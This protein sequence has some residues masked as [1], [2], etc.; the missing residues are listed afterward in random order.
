MLDQ[1]NFNKEN[2]FNLLVETIEDEKKLE[3]KYENMKKNYT[4]NVYSVIETKIK[5]L[6]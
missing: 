4:N 1:N 5:E 6:I 3:S 2:L